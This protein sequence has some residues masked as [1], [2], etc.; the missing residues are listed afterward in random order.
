MKTLYAFIFVFLGLLNVKGYA[1]TTIPPYIPIAVE[2]NY[3]KLGYHQDGTPSSWVF[4]VYLLIQGDTL[5]NGIQYKI[6]RGCAE[7]GWPNLPSPHVIKAGLRDDTLARKVYAYPFAY[8]FYQFLDPKFDDCNVINTEI[9]LFDF[10]YQ[11]GDTFDLC[12]LHPGEVG[13]ATQPSLCVIAEDTAYYVWN[14]MRHTIKGVGTPASIEGIGTNGAG[15][16]PH[17]YDFDIGY[18]LTR[19]KFIQGVGDCSEI[20]SFMEESESEVMIYPVPSTDKITIICDIT[21]FERY[22]IYSPLGI[23]TGEGKVV[24]E[25]QEIDLSFFPSGVYYLQLYDKANRVLVKK[26]IRY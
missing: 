26:V 14:K 20:L 2:G 13:S 19:E 18:G 12:W 25:N 16:L 8:G 21:R 1:Q 4:P 3:W 17:V 5:I 15:P 10:S 9:L 7:G 22:E 23:K 24:S 6:L 11:V